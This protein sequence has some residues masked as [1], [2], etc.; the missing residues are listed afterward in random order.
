MTITI[1]VAYDRNTQRTR[2]LLSILI[3]FRPSKKKRWKILSIF[4]YLY[5]MSVQ[6]QFLLK[7]LKMRI[8]ISSLA[9]VTE[10]DASG[11]Y[12]YGVVILL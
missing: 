10:F 7:I 4:I 11:E 9:I 3:H 2:L 8:K 1:I 6:I 5:Q 12:N